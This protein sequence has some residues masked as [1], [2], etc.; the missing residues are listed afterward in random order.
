[1]LKIQVHKVHKPNCEDARPH[2]INYWH[3][4]ALKFGRRYAWKDLNDRKVYNLVGSN[5][6]S[7]LGSDFGSNLGSNLG[8]DLRSE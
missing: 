4:Q 8:L 3:K 7:D 1:M 2:C 6:G 5:I